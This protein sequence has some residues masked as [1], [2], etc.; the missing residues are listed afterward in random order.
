MRSAAARLALGPVLFAIGLAVIWI[1]DWLVGFGP[2]SRAQGQ[3]L[4][5]PFLAA[6][7]GIAALVE[8]DP[9]LRQRSRRITAAMAAVL[10]VV[11]AVL[12]AGTVTQVGCRPVTGPLDVAFEA[13]AVGVMAAA[14][15][16]LAYLV[17]TDAARKGRR[18]TA[19]L[20]GATVFLGL[21]VASLLAMVT[22]FFP[23]VSCAA[24]G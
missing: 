23:I 12:I 15:Y 16:G 2:L 10:G 24:P 1:A 4:G 5:V 9:L 22:V 6:A 7:P 17:S 19:V 18:L 14:T 3:A 11:A 13:T 20:G 21:A 8:G